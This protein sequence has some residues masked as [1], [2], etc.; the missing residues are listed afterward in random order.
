M[1]QKFIIKSLCLKSRK[2]CGK[3][4]YGTLAGIAKTGIAPSTA[5]F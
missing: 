2:T 1:K 4:F 5:W 3:G